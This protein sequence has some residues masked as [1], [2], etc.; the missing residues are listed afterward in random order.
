[1]IM[2]AVDQARLRHCR[3]VQLTRNATRAD[4]T[5]F[6]ERLGFVPTHV[7]MKLESRLDRRR[8]AMSNVPPA[9]T[10]GSPPAQFTTEQLLL[11]MGAHVAKIRRSVGYV[12]FFAMLQAVLLVLWMA[13]VVTI[14]F[15][16]L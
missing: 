15:R 16:P 6:H 10:P 8:R 12:A 7:G 9:E 2:W 4:A 1:M 5:R 11:A 14:E 3:F 13:G